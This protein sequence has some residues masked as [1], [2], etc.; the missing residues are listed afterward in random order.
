MNDKGPYIKYVEGG[1]RGGGRWGRRDFVGVMKYLRH[2]LMDH[3]IFFLQ[4]F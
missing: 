2:I 3:E 1:G 4:N